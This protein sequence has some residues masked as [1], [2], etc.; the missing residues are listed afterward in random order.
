ML[1]MIFQ[2]G[3]EPVLI[4]RILII[5]EA[6]KTIEIQAIM[7]DYS[8]NF[9][10]KFS[11]LAV[12]PLEA[13]WDTCYGRPSTFYFYLKNQGKKICEGGLFKGKS[14]WKG[15]ELYTVPGIVWSFT[16]KE[17]HIGSA[18]SKILCFK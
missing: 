15:E 5:F 13:F 14:F 12:T 1:Y 10:L 8:R 2:Y 3:G 17:N 9:V 7:H 11:K 16:V 4:Q 6:I 18:V